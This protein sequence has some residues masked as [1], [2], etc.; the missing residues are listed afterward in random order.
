VFLLGALAVLLVF[1]S[2]SATGLVVLVTMLAVIPLFLMSARDP[3]L[4]I[5]VAILATLLAGGGLIIATSGEV[6]EIV[7]RDAT[8]SGRTALWAVLL[9]TAQE[10]PWLG[11]G[12]NAFWESFPVW[13]EGWVPGQ[14]HNGYLDLFL[15]LGAVGL[16]LFLGS[17][18]L[19][20]WRALQQFHAMPGPLTLWPL[21]FVCFLALCNLTES[22]NMAAHSLY[23]ALYA[24]TVVSLSPRIAERISS[25]EFERRPPRQ[26]GRTFAYPVHRST[27][28]DSH[29]SGTP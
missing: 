23:W 29:L 19:A 27:G 7:G 15:E 14:A 4:A 8:L 5:G 21:I 28:S 24:S 22:S 1:T 20:L 17:L 25:H 6:A 13:L 10:H 3:R 18:A 2:R 16:I 9:R 26:P 12:F 11:H